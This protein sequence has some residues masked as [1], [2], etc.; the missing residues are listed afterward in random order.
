VEV[1]IL[2]DNYPGETSW[3]ITN[4]CDG[5]TAASGGGYDDRGTMYSTSSCLPAAN[6]KF[7]IVD[8]YGDGIC[9][10]Y[11]SGS[12]DVKYNGQSVVSDG[13]G[14]F[15]STE[16]VTFGTQC[17][18]SPSAVNAEFNPALGVPKCS[19]AGASCRSGALLNGKE[20][21]VEPNGS[22]T[23]DSCRDGTVGSFHGDES[24]D[25]ITVSAVEGDVLT[26][27]GLAEIKAE[28]WAWNTG[29]FDTADFYYTATVNSNPTWTHIKSIRA[30][31]GGGGQT[32][33]KVEYLLPESVEQAVRVNFRYS[34]DQSSCSGGFWDDVDDLVFVVAPARAG[35]IAGRMPKQ[36]AEPKS[37]PSGQCP[38]I[39]DRNR[40]DESL[41]CGWKNGK[42]KGCY[43]IEG[44]RQK[45][46][47]N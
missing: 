29:A 2:T 24:V 12:Y 47:K 20:N 33:L 11:G 28:V 18:P 38:T 21:N 17:P 41:V 25:S 26:A 32:F 31:V 9:C 37:I 40:C 3:T 19:S 43:P 45:K 15:G 16:E 27:G 13:A 14:A 42:N 39:G 44:R 1:E 34:G 4:K 46:P 23:L 30:D 10:S 6:Y 7:E 22:N 36:I 35:T 5:S 8:S